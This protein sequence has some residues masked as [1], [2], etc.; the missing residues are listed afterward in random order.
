MKYWGSE[1][2]WTIMSKNKLEVLEYGKNRTY[3]FRTFYKQPFQSNNGGFIN[4]YSFENQ[5]RANLNILKMFLVEM[6]YERCFP[7]QRGYETEELL[8]IFQ[9]IFYKGPN[10]DFSIKYFQ[11]EIWYFYERMTFLRKKKIKNNYG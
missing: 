4:I 9:R 2:M 10:V 6:F 11:R 5:L 1:E 3:K 7:D 8:R